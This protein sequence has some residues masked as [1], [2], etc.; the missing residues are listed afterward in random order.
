MNLDHL[1][2]NVNDVEQSVRF[3]VEVMGFADEGSSEP[4]R[5]I[6]VSPDFLLLLGPWPTEGGEHLAFAM[7]RAE[8]DQVFRRVRERGLPYG[9]VFNA[10]GNMQGPALE[11]RPGGAHGRAT[12]VYFHDPNEHM[13]EIRHYEPGTST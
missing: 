12:S 2:L 3:Y 6:R 1:I 5:V 13:I 9:D 10:V 8:F 4:F 7:P 11:S